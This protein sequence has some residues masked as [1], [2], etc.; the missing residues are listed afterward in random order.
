M[1]RY[2]VLIM[3]MAGC[4]PAYTPRPIEEIKTKVVSPSKAFDIYKKDTANNFR[5]LAQDCR[6]KKFKCV[7]ELVEESVRL[8]KI[9]KIK[10]SQPIDAL[11]RDALGNKKLDTEKA[12]KVLLEV[13]DDLDPAGKEV[14]KKINETMIRYIENSFV[15]E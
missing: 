13:A 5:Q 8:D 4:V 12:I 1:C 6:D 11:F 7:N 15:G 3:L 9:A 14:P 10:R 2:L